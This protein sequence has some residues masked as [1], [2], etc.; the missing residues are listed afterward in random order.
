MLSLDDW[1]SQEFPEVSPLA[2]Y[3]DLFP[4]GELDTRNAMTKGKYC[5]VAVQVLGKK[6][7]RFTI[8]DDLEPIQKLIKEDVFTVISPLSYAG[9]SQ[10]KSMA[11]NLYAITFDVD[12]LCANKEGFP[13]GIETLLRQIENKVLPRPTYIA[14]TGN[15]N[16]HLYYMLEKAIPCFSKTL[17]E[18]TNYR[19]ELTSTIWNRYITDLHEAVQQEPV[20]QAYRAV[21]T[22]RKDKNG[23]VRV[24]LTGD[25]VTLE[26]MN[27]FVSAENKVTHYIYKEDVTPSKSNK[28]KKNRE[29]YHY[30]I[31]KGFYTWWLEQIRTKAVVGKR[32]FCICTLAIAAIKTDTSLEELRN[33]AYELIPVFDSLSP[34]NNRFTKADVDKALSFYQPSYRYTRKKTFE[35]MTGI[36]MPEHKR[37]GRTKEQ[38]MKYLNGMNAVRRSLGENLGAGRPTKEK[39]IKEFAAANPDMNYSQIARALNVDRKTVSKWLK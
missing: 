19:A 36:S 37:N 10:S 26:Y 18:L 39:L 7:K 4:I 17:D 32:Y 24:Y 23:R 28:N 8:T 11:R 6:A 2:F 27:E 29:L 3:R 20:T 5:G 1:L 34:A 14:V 15:R 12:N 13:V 31:N 35:R 21:G 22:I 16:I 9:K 38:H 25:K 30:T 33:D